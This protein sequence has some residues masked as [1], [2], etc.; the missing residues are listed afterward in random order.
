M[1]GWGAAA[2]AEVKGWLT[3]EDRLREEMSSVEEHMT[4]RC[5]GDDIGAFKLGMV[6]GVV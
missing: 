2:G 4:E 3:E 5:A 6:G 1:A